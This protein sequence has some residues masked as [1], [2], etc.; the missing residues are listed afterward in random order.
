M[1]VFL[2]GEFYTTIESAVYSLSGPSYSP[3]ISYANSRWDRTAA[4]GHSW[5]SGQRY[6]SPAS[7]FIVKTI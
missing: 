5:A 6:D 4:T 7:E 1:N 3:E 2:T